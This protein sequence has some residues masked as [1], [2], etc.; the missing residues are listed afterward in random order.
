MAELD[1]VGLDD[2]MLSLD[3]VAQMPENVQT[4]MLLAGADVVCAAQRKK[5]KA[6]G[7]YDQQSAIHVADSIKVG[8]PKIRKGVRV[9]HVSPTGSRR[10]GK[11][12]TRNTEILFVNEYGTKNQRAR[13][14]IRD[15]NEESAQATTEAQMKV[16]DKYLQSKDL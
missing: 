5:V 8:K 11:R 9:V 16:W 6:Y 4:D 15:A 13:P 3:D 2:L 12:M 7:I 10:R 1:C 14:A